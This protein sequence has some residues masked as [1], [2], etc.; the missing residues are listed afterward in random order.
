MD[1]E[2]TKKSP[3][4]TY[5]VNSDEL[6]PYFY[7]HPAENHIGGT[8]KEIDGS[9][10]EMKSVQDVLKMSWN[11]FAEIPGDMVDW[12]NKTVEEMMRVQDYLYKIE[13]IKNDK[14]PSI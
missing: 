7:I 11:S 9:G 5:L 12:I 2:I 14:E 4:N 1:L 8:A 13:R 10:W 3:S 6:Y